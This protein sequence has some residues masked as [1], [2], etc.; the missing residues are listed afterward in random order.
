L[1]AEVRCR[2]QQL[3]ILWDDQQPNVL[4]YGTADHGAE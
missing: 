4:A 3:S 2:G 1:R